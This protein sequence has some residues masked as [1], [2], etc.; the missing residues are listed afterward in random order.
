MTKNELKKLIREM[1][2]E[3]VE[4]TQSRYAHMRP[5]KLE[6]AKIIS[7]LGALNDKIE[8]KGPLSEEI[9]D[10]L[11]ALGELISNINIGR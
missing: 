6:I 10:A 9:V 5:F 4:S 3:E 7:Q 8:E 1:L 2:S 11:E